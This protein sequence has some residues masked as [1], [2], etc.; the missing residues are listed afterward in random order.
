MLR[1]PLFLLLC[2]LLLTT[3]CLRDEVYFAY[4]SADVEG[5]DTG[6]H[7]GFTVDSL[8]QGRTYHPT[9]HLRT[10]AAPVYPF[11]TIVLIV[12][13]SWQFPH[14]SVSR[15]DSVLH[16]ADT[17]TLRLMT[18]SGHPTT[19]GLALRQYTHPLPS[20]RLPRGARG[21][22]DVRHI[23]RKEVVPGIA[24]IGYSLR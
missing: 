23:M 9:L 3:A 18:S 24:N 17:L 5:W 4:R 8:A 16:T 15:R 22:I 7:I 14:P 11:Q 6:E 1:R 2:S 10:T 13:Q 12:S 20:L 21:K 19:E